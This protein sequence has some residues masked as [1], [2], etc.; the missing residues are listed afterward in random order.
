MSE[1][2]VLKVCSKCKQPFPHNADHFPRDRSQ[3]SGLDSRCK[4]CTKVKN[5]LY[6]EVNRPQLALKK[7]MKRLLDPE[8]YQK[9]HLAAYQRHPEKYCEASRQYRRKHKAQVSAYSFA[10]RQKHP[11][12]YQAARQRKRAKK[13]NALLNDLTHAQWLEIQEAYDHR[14]VYCGKRRK[15]HLTQDHLTPLSHGGNHTASNILPACSS[16]NSRKNAGPV[17]NPVQPL[18]LT[19]ASPRPHAS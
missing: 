4:A 11:E 18:L 17:L 14:C 8:S 6:Q 1:T 3:K 5:A 10:Y 2:I 7:R 15:G 12:I 16:C 19:L 13:R 9:E